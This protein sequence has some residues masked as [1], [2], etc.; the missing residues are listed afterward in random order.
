MF[1]AISVRAH[2]LCSA[3]DAHKFY[4]YI[5]QECGETVYLKRCTTKRSHFE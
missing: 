4:R 3:D 5:C 2:K 1:Y